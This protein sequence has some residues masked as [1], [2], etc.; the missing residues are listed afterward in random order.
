MIFIKMLRLI[1]LLL[2]IQF[3]I[4]SAQPRRVLQGQLGRIVCTKELCWEKFASMKKAGKLL[5][6]FYSKSD[7]PTKGC[8]VKGDSMYF[9]TGGTLAEM[10]ISDLSGEKKRVWCDATSTTS[11]EEILSDNPRI[12]TTEEQCKARYITKKQTGDIQG[13]FYASI[14][15]KTKGCVM[16]GDNVYFGIGGTDE[17]MALSFLTGQQVRVWCNAAAEIVTTATTTTT[18]TTS[19]QF[20]D[21]ITTFYLMAD[22]PYSA[23]ERENLMPAHVAGIGVDA[24][25]LVHLGDLHNG[26]EDNCEEWAYQSASSILRKSRVPTFVLPGDNDINDCKDIGQGNAMWAKYFKRIDERWN[27][28]FNVTRWGD[29]D[30]SFSFLRKGVLFFGVNIP[31]GKPNNPSD[32]MERF[33]EHLERI[34][35]ILNGL[36]DDEY[37]V[38]VLLGHVDPTY[39]Q[40]GSSQIFFNKFAD[41]VKNIGKPT[42]YFHGDF[43]KYYETEGGDYDVDNYLRISLDGESIS[44]PLRVEID[45]SRENPIEVSRR[46]SGLSVDCCSDGWPRNEVL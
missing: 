32:A 15:Y 13:Y 14:D 5:G 20:S 34:G 42:V 8:F 29:L 30:E 39:G 46:R 2:A 17:E 38:M 33:D 4:G 24:E 9:G 27:H 26:H 16:K 44:P 31:G 23:N 7:I 41:I 21:T 11:N 12:C 19:A 35:S 37:K 43:H 18:S 40:A 45:V 1:T 28:D 22:C 3:K 10:R 25:F 36:S 6:Y